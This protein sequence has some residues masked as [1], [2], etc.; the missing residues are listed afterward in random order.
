M[1]AMLLHSCVVSLY[2]LSFCLFL[3]D[4]SQIFLVNTMILKIS[5]K[6]AISYM[7]CFG[8]LVDALLCWLSCCLKVSSRCQSFDKGILLNFTIF[9][10]EILIFFHHSFCASLAQSITVIQELIDSLYCRS[11]FTDIITREER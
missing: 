11:R 9:Q 7:K 6:C 10:I 3:L 8:K 4:C 5:S 2:T 1:L